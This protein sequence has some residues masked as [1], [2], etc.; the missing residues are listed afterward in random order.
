MRAGRLGAEGSWGHGKNRIKR[1]NVE[2]KYDINESEWDTDEIKRR[3]D[4]Y[5]VK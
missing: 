4:E 3:K 5:T 2:T 1:S